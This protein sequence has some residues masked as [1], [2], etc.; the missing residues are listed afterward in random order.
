MLNT[1]S[2]TK[3]PP[4]HQT[5][6]IKEFAKPTQSNIE[7]DSDQRSPLHGHNLR[8]LSTR[9]TP[10]KTLNLSNQKISN[11]A[12]Q[13]KIAEKRSQMEINDDENESPQPKIVCHF[14]TERINLPRG[15]VLRQSLLSSTNGSKR[16]SQSPPKIPH[17][18]MNQ[19]PKYAEKT[20]FYKEYW[21]LYLQ[22]ENL[23]ADIEQT[24]HSNY[25]MLKKI[26][27]LE[28]YYEHHLIPQLLT[29]P[30]RFIH[31]LKQ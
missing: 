31:R 8:S 19:E 16:N 20:D 15:K 30:H 18:L 2:L 17:A 28:D 22:N 1:Q 10:L 14:A 29:Y 6:P 3:L 7:E 12:A 26:Y 4:S 21:K 11:T 27:N 9:K 13:S 25:K 5:P 24:A 23:V